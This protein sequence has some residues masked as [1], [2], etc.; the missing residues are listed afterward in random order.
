[1][2]P[3][4]RTNATPSPKRSVAARAA[5]SARLVFPTPPGPVT[6]TSRAVRSSSPHPLQVGV[7]AEERGQPRR[8]PRPG[9]RR[10]RVRTGVVAARAGAARSARCCRIASCRLAQLRAGFQAELGVEHGPGALVGGERVGLPPGPVEREHQPAVQP[11]TQR[12]GGGELLEVAEHLGVPAGGQ[13]Q[14][15][16]FLPGRQLQ[17]GQP[18]RLRPRPTPASANSASAGPRHGRQRLPVEPRGRD[19]IGVGGGAGRRHLI[20]EAQRVDPS[21]GRRRAGSPAAG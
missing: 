14:V 16:Q 4:S 20:G 3:A 13:L 10:A 21:R 2:T 15:D 19:R 11:L 9:R 12:M 5:S 8:Q 7:A 1:M 18:G 6:V 17:L